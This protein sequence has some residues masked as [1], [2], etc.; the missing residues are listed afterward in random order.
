MITSINPVN[1]YIVIQFFLVIRTLRSTLLSTLKYAIHYYCS[2]HSAHYTLM[3]YSFY[4]LKCIRFNLLHP[5]DP[6]PICNF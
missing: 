5:C 6:L 2:H 4:N 3:T 1:I